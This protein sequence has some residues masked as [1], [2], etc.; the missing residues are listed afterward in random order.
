MLPTRATVWACRPRSP[1]VEPGGQ[2]GAPCFELRIGR[3]RPKLLQRGDAGRGG[4]RIA[5]ERAGLKH[6]TGGQDVIHDFGTAA[7]GT[8]RQPAAHDFSQR[9]QVGLDL[10]GA[11]GATIRHAKPGHHLVA[12]QQRPRV[13]VSER[14]ASRNAARRN[15][16]A[17]VAD[18]RLEDDRGDPRS[19][20]VETRSSAARSLYSNT[21]VSRVRAT[22]DPRRIRHTERRGRAAGSHQQAI[23][24][25]VIVA[26][27]FDDHVA[28]GETACQANRTQRRLGAGV[29]EPHLFDR[30]HGLDD[31]LG[32][33][34][35][36]LRRCAK[37]VPRA[38]ASATAATTAGWL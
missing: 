15:Y 13:S 27:E 32:Q 26:G 7:V 34:A 21:S 9:R 8:D 20:L 25:P 10:T 35:F 28:A 31:Q 22:G 18:D 29:D 12:D 14:S 30:R 33:L 5:A 24:V 36:G 3:P 6:F 2:L 23:D 1:R 11:I 16:A 17:H 4:Q 37:L 38:A 19:V